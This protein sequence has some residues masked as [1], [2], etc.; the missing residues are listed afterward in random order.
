MQALLDLPNPSN[1]LS[2]LQS[3]HDAI[4]R[5]MRSLSTLGKSVDSY[6]DLLVPITLNKLPQKTRK[7]MVREHDSNE[8]NLN[9]L[10]EA[11]RKEVRVFESE[12][13]TNHLSQTPHPTATFHA[14]ARANTNPS[15]P[16]TN[17]RICTFCK[18]AHSPIECKVVVD[19]KARRT[20]WHKRTFA[21][22]AWADTKSRFVYQNTNVVNATENITPVYVLKVLQRIKML[23]KNLLTPVQH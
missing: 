4:E 10:Q 14:G 15:Q 23:P 12:F 16:S 20:W 9:D 5:H 19:A 11:I 8:W 3:F 22:I 6:G 2:G 18:G 17:Q 7:N 21:S 13:V 1:T